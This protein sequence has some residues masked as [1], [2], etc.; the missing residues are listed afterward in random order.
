M[1][2]QE[3]LAI[4]TDKKNIAVI[5]QIRPIFKS[6]PNLPKGLTF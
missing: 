2:K 1:T 5:D 3:L 4:L 6:A